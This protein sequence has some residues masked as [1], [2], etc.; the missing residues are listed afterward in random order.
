MITNNNKLKVAFVVRNLEYVGGT[1]KFILSYI[2][3]LT[4]KKDIDLSIYCLEGVGIVARN[5]RLLGVKVFDVP[6]DWFEIYSSYELA[7]M[8]KKA[9]IDIVHTHLFNADVIGGIAA[10]IAGIPS[11]ST[12]YCMFSRALEKNT[13]FEKMILKPI[14]DQ[15]LEKL[16]DKMPGKIFVVSEGVKKYF[17]SIGVPV[18]KM[19]VAPCAPIDITKPKIVIS[20]IKARSIFQLPKTKIII[21]ST[22][23][24]VPEKGIDTL[25]FAFSLL[26][27]RNNDV[28]LVIAGNGFLKHELEKLALSLGI[29]DHVFFLGQIDNIDSFLSCLDIFVLASRSEG[30][31]LALQEAM[32]RELPIVATNVGGIPELMDKNKDLLVSSDQPALLA[33]K[34]TFL[35]DNMVLWK[36]V[37]GNNKRSIK[38]KF[39]IAKVYDL[40]LKNYKQLIQNRKI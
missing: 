2:N 35:L 6:S 1:E 32:W 9:E 21:G 33:E 24:L 14:I 20:K 4:T 11:I 10:L 8:F 12:K 26:I 16:V 29:S 5:L 25:L 15:F 30:F 36:T 3:F 18:E 27:K 28:C 31:P 7:Q 40:I 23:R 38:E 13:R 19:V 34:I 22:T 37:G 17:Q 39:N